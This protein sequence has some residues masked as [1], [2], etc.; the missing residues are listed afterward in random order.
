LKTRDNIL[1]IYSFIKNKKGLSACLPARGAKAGGNAQAGLSMVEIL[2]AASIF[3]V[4]FTAVAA[5]YAVGINLQ[6]RTEL[7]TSA[8]LIGQFLLEYFTSNFPLAIVREGSYVFMGNLPYPEGAYAYLNSTYPDQAINREALTS[9]DWVK[10][11]DKAHEQGSFF[12][13]R[14]FKS[15]L[16]PHPLYFPYIFM[17]DGFTSLPLNTT[18]SDLNKMFESPDKTNQTILFKENPIRIEINSFPPFFIAQSPELLYQLIVRESTFVPSNPPSSPPLP[19]NEERFYEV[20]IEV[21]WSLKGKP[22]QTYEIKT[23]VPY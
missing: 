4:L 16:A 9:D 2:V 23:L 15:E 1:N 22:P 21:R 13:E 7:G 5:T 11:Y 14:Y 6:Y 12:Y 8:E 3:F 17:I 10:I 18:V 20:T 19:P